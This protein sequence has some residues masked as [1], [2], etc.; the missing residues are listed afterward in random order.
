M[1]RGKFTLVFA[2]IITTTLSMAA[3]APAAQRCV[4]AEMFTSTGCSACPTAVA[5]MD[6]VVKYD[7][8]PDELAVIRCGLGYYFTTSGYGRFVWYGGQY[9]PTYFGDGIDKIVGNQGGIAPC[10][11]AYKSSISARLPVD[12]PLEMDLEI[13]YGARGDTG[14][15]AVQIVATD[16]IPYTSL[17]VR[18]CIVEDGLSY[19]G[20]AYNQMLRGYF[21]PTAPAH[22]GTPVSISEG[23]TVIHTDEFVMDPSWVPE[24]C[25]VVAFVQNGVGVPPPEIEQEMI[26]GVQAPVLVSPPAEVAGLTVTLM[27][28]DLALEWAPVTTDASGGPMGIDH[29]QVYRDTL[30]FFGPGSDPFLTTTDTVCTDTSGVIGNLDRHY[31]YAVTAV[32]GADE[33]EVSGEVGEFDTYLDLGYNLISWPVEVHGDD[34]QAVFADSGGSGCQLTG[35]FPAANSDQVKYYDAALGTWY[36]AWYKIGGPGAS[37][38]WLGDLATVEADQSYWIVIPAIHTPVILTMTGT[39]N[40]GTRTIP[41]QP[42]LSHNYVGTC[43]TVDRPLDGTTG[44]GCHLLDSGLTG[45]YPATSSDKIRYYDGVTW[46]L[47][48]YKV[49]GPGDDGWQGDM[50]SLEP[51]NGYVLELLAGNAFTGDQWNYGEPPAKGDKSDPPGRKPS[52]WIREHSRNVPRTLSPSTNRSLKSLEP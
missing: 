38:L 37:Y 22:A 34:I 18:T 13:D 33:S 4:V 19:G 26:Q 50:S 5:A 45:G 10:W 28:D 51:G 35:G 11:A 23:D 7:F 36:T 42:G 44:D 46:Y 27:S 12:T 32:A 49:G 48:W 15:V 2:G 43:W 41:V 24:N 30:G 40:P 3:T 39:A 29:Y 17:R 47:A 8:T 31:Y 25:R 52:A 21:C 14:T 1:F 20:R 6:S 9:T 16:T